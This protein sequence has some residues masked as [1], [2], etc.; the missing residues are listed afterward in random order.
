MINGHGNNIYQYKKGKIKIDFSSNI[1]FNNHSDT[2]LGYIS[3]FMSVLKNYPDPNT[4]KLCG[5]IGRHHNVKSDNILVVNGSAEGFY[6]VAHYIA[7]SVNKMAKSLIFIP[8]FAEYE[9]S[10]LLFEH[11]IAFKNIA[12]FEDAD[13]S[14]FDSCWL[15]LPNNPDGYRV[16]SDK[17]IENCINYPN[18]IFVVDMAYNDL[19]EDARYNA[20]LTAG[21]IKN[22]II[23][24]SLTKSFGIPG[25]RL[26]YIIGENSIIEKLSNM[27]PPWSVNALSIV[28]GEFIMDNYIE[29]EL[30]KNELLGESRFL[31]CEI[32]KIDGFRVKK[33][34][35]NFFLCE[36]LGKSDVKELK[37]YLIEEHGILVRDCSNF[38][39][40]S[41]K[42]FRIAAQNH[43]SNRQLIEALKMFSNRLQ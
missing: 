3:N 22:L 8:S 13:F 11:N 40:L 17:I 21:E 9:D 24:S 39:S 37:N 18:C 33:S 7:R 5:K 41:S 31:Q 23:L 25:L 14:Q 43:T 2:V 29:L 19:C 4:V 10:C 35:S 27:R 20:A 38:R 6:L 34:P 28:A 32:S 30:D 36:I 16:E 12:E 15:G 42:Y 1:A 26:G